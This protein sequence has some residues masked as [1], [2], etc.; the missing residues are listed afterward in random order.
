MPWCCLAAA[1]F[2]SFLV[3]RRLRACLSILGGYLIST[4]VIIVALL[5]SMPEFATT[6]CLF[7]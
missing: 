5:S 4:T 2:E 3:S 6:Y 7:R 1:G